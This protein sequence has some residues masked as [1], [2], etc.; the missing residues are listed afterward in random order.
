MIDPVKADTVKNIFLMRG[1]GEKWSTIIKLLHSQGMPSPT[2]ESYWTTGTLAEM[3]KKR[4]YVGEVHMG[5]HVTR[6][7]HKR[8]V[9]EAQWK[10]AQSKPS[11]SGTASTLPC[12]ARLLTCTG[13]GIRCRCSRAGMAT[14]S[15][16]ADET[17]QRP[18][19]APVTGK[20][21]TIDDTSTTSRAR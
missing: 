15:T 19:P 5:G 18:C 14:R 13:A 4:V 12:R 17:A 8:I 21:S 16:G 2:G 1:A 11:R 9:T 6:K 10:A 3:V 7:A 20:Q